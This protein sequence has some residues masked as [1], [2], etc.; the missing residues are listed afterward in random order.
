MYTYIKLISVVK[1]SSDPLQRLNHIMN[2]FRLSIMMHPAVVVCGLG[3]QSERC[4]EIV[5]VG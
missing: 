3:Q 1:I 5:L 4:R 2:T